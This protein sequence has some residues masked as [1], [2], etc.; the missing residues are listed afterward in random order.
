MFC[1]ECGAENL[2]VAKFCRFCGAPIAAEPETLPQE[3]QPAAQDSLARPSL[4]WWAIPAIALPCLLAFLQSS[5]R[6]GSLSSEQFGYAIGT[7]LLPLIIAYACA[8]K[9]PQRWNKF[10]KYFFGLLLCLS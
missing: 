2:D 6:Y 3:P 9:G 4:E 8:Q 10:A 7:L 1:S 5:A